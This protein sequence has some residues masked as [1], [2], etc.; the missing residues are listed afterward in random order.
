MDVPTTTTTVN[1]PATSLSSSS[2]STTES[3]HRSCQKC[4]KRISSI[5]FDKHNICIDCR[6]S[7]C[8]LDNRCKECK[9]WSLEDME[10]Y[11]K[12]RKSLD[13]KGKGKGKKEKEK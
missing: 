6:G 7:I 5:K 1:L 10:T 3:G 11:V 9:T 8:D 12:H 2:S 4:R 13:S